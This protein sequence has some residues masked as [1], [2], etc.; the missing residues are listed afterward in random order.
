MGF[1]LQQNKKYTECGN[2]GPGKNPLFKYIS[3]ESAHFIRNGLMT[4]SVDMR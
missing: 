2:Q 1:N 4:I 3:S